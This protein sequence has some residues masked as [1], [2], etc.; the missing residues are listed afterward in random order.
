[1]EAANRGAIQD[2]IRFV[3]R[4]E[5]CS[6]EALMRRVAKGAVVILKVPFG[7]GSEALGIGEGLRIKVNTNV[8]TC[9]DLV[10]TDLELQ[11][12]KLAVSLG[13]DTIMDLSTAGDL[14]GIRR[15]LLHSLR[16]PLGTVPIYQAAIDSIERRGSIVDMDEDYI[17]DV[18]ERHGKDGVAFMTLH[19]GITRSIVEHL[20]GQPRVTGIVSRG[21]SFLTAWIFHNGKENPLYSQFEYILEL[22]KKYD[23]CLSLGDA[24]RPGCLA[25]ASDHLQTEELYTIGRLVERA[26]KAGVQAMVEGPGHMPLNQIAANVIL[27]KAVCKGAPYYLLGPLVTDLGAPYDHIVAAIGSAV[28]GMAGADFLCVVTSAEH[29][30]FPMLED[31]RHGVVAAKLAAHAL[32]IVRIGENAMEL[33]LR[34]A[35]ARARL[36]WDEQIRLS[37]DPERAKKVHM[38]VPTKTGACSMCGP[39][40]T[41]KILARY[42]GTDQVMTEKCL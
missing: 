22:A 40:C 12:A 17:L 19:S 1:M 41:Y 25:D 16:V 27:E 37:I 34:M 6:P 26:R 42:L 9:S 7:E 11:K 23:F 13:S 8:G 24:L 21:G 36:D 29:L 39:Y 10:D 18:I 5:G 2:E 33:D 32:D 20:K 38:A 3:A 28:A 30:G 31:I 4:A 15:S 35:K 14:D